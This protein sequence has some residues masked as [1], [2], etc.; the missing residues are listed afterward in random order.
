[1]N[2]VTAFLSWSLTITS[3]MATPS[4]DTCRACG[5]FISDAHC[6]VLPAPALLVVLTCRG[7]ARVLDWPGL[8][9]EP[10][11]QTSASGGAH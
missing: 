4:S 1:M 2:Y 11:L 8:Q 3:M 7:H 5:G 9:R 6:R 10:L